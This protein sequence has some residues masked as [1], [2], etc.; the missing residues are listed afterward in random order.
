MVSVPEWPEVIEDAKILFIPS[1]DAGSVYLCPHAT[2]LEEI[3]PLCKDI[4][5]LDVGE[6]KK[7]IVATTTTYNDQ[8]YYLVLGFTNGGVGVNLPSEADANGP[9]QGYGGLPIIFD[10]SN[11]S[12]PNNDPLQYRWD[13]NNDESWDTEWLSTSTTNHIWN[14]DYEGIIKLEVSDGQFTAIATTSVI[15]KSPKTFKEDA[16]SELEAAKSGDKKIDKKIDKIIWFINRS[17]DEKLWVDAS[18]LVFFEKD[19]ENFNEKEFEELFD[20]SEWTGPKSG[21]L[22]FHYEK[23]AVKLMMNEIKFKE[24]PAELK[25]VFEKVIAKLVKADR[26]LAKVSLYDAKNTPIKNP[27]FERMVKRQIEK[28]AEELIKAEN[29]LTKNRPDKAIMRFGKS[30]LH[31]QLAIKFANL[32]EK[33]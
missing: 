16:I 2:S 8:D 29:E 13:F 18:H 3:T 20:K 24:T 19:F 31:S 1:T 10:A 17:L 33:P 32:S 9:Y 28:A 27:K 5:V 25:S 26:L 7:G 4:V 30:C 21:I 12:D 6:T 14:D 22:V 15:V 11:S 23:E